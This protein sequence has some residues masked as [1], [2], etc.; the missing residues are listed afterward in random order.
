MKNYL[1]VIFTLFLFNNIF[2]QEKRTQSKFMDSC[3]ISV[4]N[5]K[6]VSINQP[7]DSIFKIT[8]NC[9]ESRFSLKFFDRWGKVLYSTSDINEKINWKNLPKGKLFWVLEII[10]PNNK[11]E[12]LSDFIEIQ[13]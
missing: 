8:C 13:E 4:H 12:K 6:I 11:R 9:Y 5:S 7:S 1:F 2:S 10:Y 3:K